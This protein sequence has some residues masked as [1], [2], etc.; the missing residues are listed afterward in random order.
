MAAA[1]MASSLSD[2]IQLAD[3][4]APC[5]DREHEP[6]IH[7][8]L[9]RPSDGPA[10]YA[11]LLLEVGLARQ[12]VRDLS[13]RYL[14]TQDCRELLIQRRRVTL[15]DF[16]KIT[17]GNVLVRQSLRYVLSVLDVQSVQYGWNI[18]GDACSTVSS[19]P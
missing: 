11:V 7:Q 1:V 12:H 3:E 5:P 9:N 16:H 6:F 18:L 2:S 10:R 13:G 17:V 8:D 4:R 19:R 15:A 14:R